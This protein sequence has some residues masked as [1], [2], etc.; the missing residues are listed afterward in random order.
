MEKGVLKFKQIKVEG[1]IKLSLGLS[2]AR[3]KCW[4]EKEEKREMNIWKKSSVVRKIENH[5]KERTQ[6]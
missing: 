6:I 3:E 1:N 5:R 2:E 4:G